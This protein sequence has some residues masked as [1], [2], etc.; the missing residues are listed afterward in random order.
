MRRKCAKT[1]YFE[2]F[3]FEEMGH[4]FV[5]RC[6]FIFCGRTGPYISDVSL[7]TKTRTHTTRGMS[8][9]RLC[10][11]RLHVCP[12]SKTYNNEPLV[13]DTAQYEADVRIAEDNLKAA[14]LAHK[15]HEFRLEVV[16][17]LNAV[18]I[19]AMGNAWLEKELDVLVIQAVNVCLEECMK[20]CVTNIK[21]IVYDDKIVEDWRLYE[22]GVLRW[23]S[24]LD[25]YIAAQIAL[26]KEE[27]LTI[28]PDFGKKYSDFVVLHTRYFSHFEVVQAKRNLKKSKVNT[29]K[30]NGDKK[31]KASVE[32]G[33]GGG[34]SQGSVV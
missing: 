20:K 17:A 10:P 12:L 19:P 24:E 25:D 31:R 27:V 7:K 11:L 33:G 1:V 5:N 2:F 13:N 32:D 16:N 14:K 8:N 22:E 34:M 29:S 9:A 26:F 4:L 30:G 3:V 28:K 21:K 6:V 23:K 18:C 15:R